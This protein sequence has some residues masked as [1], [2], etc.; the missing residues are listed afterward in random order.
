VTSG[1]IVGFA[2]V[3]HVGGIGSTAV[4][5]AAGTAGAE[6]TVG[7]VYSEGA[8]GMVVL[9]AHGKPEGLE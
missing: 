1:G 2:G 8:E 9:V 7:A 6:D 4:E 3:E 5:G